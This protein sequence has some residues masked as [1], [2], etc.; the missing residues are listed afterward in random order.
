MVS[1]VLLVI[2]DLAHR[3]QTLVC[4]TH[5]MGFAREV[6]D[7]VLFMDEGQVLESATPADFF[8]RPQHPRAQKFLA[9]LRSPFDGH[10]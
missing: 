3:G 7:R 5:E 1:E 6:A 10:R 4:V 8:Q 9:D 2:R